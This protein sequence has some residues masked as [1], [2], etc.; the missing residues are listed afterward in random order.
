MTVEDVLRAHGWSVGTRGR[1]NCPLH[2][3]SNLEAFSYIE[4]TWYCFAQCGGGNAVQLAQRLG[5]HYLRPNTRVKGLLIAVGPRSVDGKGSGWGKPSQRLQRALTLKQDHIH[6]EALK[7]HLGALH[8]LEMVG[9]MLQCVEPGNEEVFEWA[10]EWAER[11]Y[12]ML[13]WAHVVFVRHSTLEA[14]D[15]RGK[16]AW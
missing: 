7:R 15:C 8:L 12:K 5:V 1:T 6:H 2:E 9:K 13:D 11:A 10:G 4:E 16:E 14:C 3:G